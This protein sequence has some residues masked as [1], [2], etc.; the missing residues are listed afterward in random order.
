LAFSK[1]E[2]LMSDTLPIRI[3]TE[4]KKRLNAIAANIELEEWQLGD[5]EAGI[6]D[7]V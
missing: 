6:R 7:L 3:D 5:I 2:C 4:T 1:T